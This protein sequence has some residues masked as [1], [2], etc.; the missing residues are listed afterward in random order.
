MARNVLNSTHTHSTLVH[1]IFTLSSEGLRCVFYLC[2][3]IQAWLGARPPTI[4]SNAVI[5]NRRKGEGSAGQQAECADQSIQAMSGSRFTR[6]SPAQRN[7]LGFLSILISFLL[8]P[9]FFPRSVCHL[10]RENRSCRPVSSPFLLFNTPL[11]SP[12][13]HSQDQYSICMYT[14]MK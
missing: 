3:C 11:P 1:C 4:G 2:V 13:L 14:R 5:D 12:T 7:T 6:N 8:S 9:P 10:S